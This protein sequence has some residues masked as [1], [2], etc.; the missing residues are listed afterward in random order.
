MAGKTRA[1]TMVCKL[2]VRIYIESIYRL[3]F[4]FVS[5]RFYL[6]CPLFVPFIQNETGFRLVLRI[7][8]IRAKNNSTRNSVLAKQPRLAAATR[9]L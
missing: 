6:L 1:Q 4:V 7:S 3:G 9:F 2:S 5:A 8:F